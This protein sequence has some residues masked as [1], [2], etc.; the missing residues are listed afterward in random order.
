MRSAV[1]QWMIKTADLGL[2]P[3]A[4]MHR[5]A[6]DTPPRQFALEHPEL[7]NR[8]ARIAFDA[9][10]TDRG[11]STDELVELSADSQSGIRF[12]SVRGLSIRP[13]KTGTRAE[14]ALLD[15]MRDPSPSVAIAACEGLLRSED[16][17]TRRQAVE[18]LLEL[19]NVETVGHFAAIAA[20]N[21][22]DMQAKLNKEQQA[23]LRSLPRE[24]KRPPA[25]V[26]KYVGKLIDHALSP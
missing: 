6:G 4:E 24:A 3:E 20:M 5:L 7:F 2:L 8:L 12:W 15:A 26:G 14:K 10:D 18:R 19:A 23:E 16:E 11:M 1:Q 17:P 13:I 22:L 21:V 25:R 9:L